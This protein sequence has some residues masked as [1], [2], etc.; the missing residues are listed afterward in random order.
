MTQRALKWTSEWVPTNIISAE[1]ERYRSY[2]TGLGVLYEGDC[3]EILPLIQNETVDTVFADP[4]FNLAKN[5]GANVT[6][7]L[8]EDKYVNWCKKWLSECTRILK[9][10]GS[11]FVYNLPKWNLLRGT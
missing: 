10:G 1:A 2:A 4:P 3:L 9:P 7:E 11:F 6:D 8:P 5:Y